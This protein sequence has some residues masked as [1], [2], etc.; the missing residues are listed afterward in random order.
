M[1]GY[2]DRYQ[3]IYSKSSHSVRIIGRSKTQDIVDS[4]IDVTSSGINAW[5]IKAAT[6]GQAAKI[7]CAPYNINV[8]L[9]DGDAPL[10][11]PSAAF[12]IYPGFTGYALLEEMAR[13]TGMLLWDNEKG[14][15]VI[16]KGGTGGRAGSGLV[17][18]KNAE[19][20]EANLT[21][22]QRFAKYL[23]VGQGPSQAF[24]SINYSAIAS[25]PES[26]RLRGRLKIIPF[27]VPGSLEFQQ[28]RADWEANRRY[29]RSKLARVTVSGWRDGSG[30]LWKPNTVVSVNLPTAKVVEDRVITE[31]TWLRGEGGTQS[32]ITVMPKEALSVQPFFTVLPVPLV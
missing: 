9:P 20:V 10:P 16:S 28:L 18:G 3:P 1:T 32:I 4:S 25:D 13:A 5:Q 11:V 14:E 23:V 29:G 2:I 30:Q 19:Q 17:E 6:I 15:L 31:V 21:A 7:V 27:E 8:S 26:S 22:D 24:G 12:A